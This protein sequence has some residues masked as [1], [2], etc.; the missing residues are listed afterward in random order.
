MVFYQGMLLLGYIYAHSIQRWI[1][2]RRY[3][4]VH[5]ILLAAPVLLFPFRFDRFGG[6][7]AGL[8]VTV[9]VF[10]LL[11]TSVSLPFVA[12]STTSLVLQ[13]WLSATALEERRNPYVLYGASNLGSMLGL[14]TYPTLAAPFL[15]LEAQGYV[16]WGAY[17]LMVFLHVFCAPDREVAF[18]AG[19]NRAETISAAC[20]A[21][22]FVLSAAGCATLLSVTNVITFD[23]ASVPLLWILPLSIYLS[24]FVLTFKR[25][26][27]FPA[28]SQSLLYWLVIL[29]VLLHM[30]TQLRLRL[31]AWLSIGIHLFIL[32]VMCLNCNANLVRRKPGVEH[33]TTFY[34]VIALGGFAG[35]VLVSWIIPLVS[36]SLVEYLLSFVLV[37]LGLALCPEPAR[38][39]RGV[40]SDGRLRVRWAAEGAALLLAAVALTAVPWAAGHFLDADTESASYVFVMVAVPLVVVM[41]RAAG[42]PWKTVAVL[43]IAT[44]AMSGTEDLFVGATET[45]RLRNF[46]G[47]YKVYDKGNLRFLQHGTTQHGRQYIS[48][49]KHDTALAYYHPT[50]PAAGILMSDHFNFRNIGMVGLGTGALVSYAERGQTF[51]VYELDPDNLPVAEENFTYIEIAGE[52]GA[53][54][55]FVFGDGRVS[56][57]NE[58]EDTLDLLIIDAFNSGSIPVH[59]LTVEAFR[60]YF[61]VLRKDGLL[62]LHVSNKVLDLAPVVYSG[63]EILGAAAC[64]KSNEQSSHPDAEDT[65]WMAVSEDGMGVESLTTR[66]GWKTRRFEAGALPRAWTDQYSNIFGTMLR[67]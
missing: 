3:S 5:W 26:M 63:A 45:K 33:L 52:N 46:Y 28:W 8:P 39:G 2:L 51:I 44:V 55:S 53:N 36:S 7:L 40:S 15:S 57:R 9:R 17:F 32:F 34:L 18:Q 38:P 61:R 6:A 41:R 25:R 16:W 23:V 29:G 13:K 37:V 42:R 22:W 60:E 14:L 50:T 54:L 31:P 59:L 24:T 56:L 21:G 35:S 48:G 67:R 66:L 64:E 4:K 19:E 58:G 47:I 20:A 12:L 62:L 1:G 43:L 27:W 65:Y 10:G 30:M 49:P 11:L